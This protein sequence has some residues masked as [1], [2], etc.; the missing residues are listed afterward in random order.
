MK[1]VKI[2]LY[3]DQPTE[4]VAAQLKEWLE[5]K[6]DV[7]ISPYSSALT[8]FTD[9]KNNQKWDIAIVDLDGSSE[10]CSPDE[11]RE[12]FDDALQGYD[13]SSVLV[14]AIL[15]IG[16]LNDWISTKQFGVGILA[17]LSIFN[18]KYRCVLTNHGNEATIVTA[19]SSH[20]LANEVVM[21]KDLYPSM[22]SIIDYLIKAIM[23]DTVSPDYNSPYAVGLMVASGTAPF[24][25]RSCS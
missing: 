12:A 10:Q 24:S 8:F 22:Q 5:K 2:L 18:C 16:N 9:I 21:S 13:V 14:D 1:K 11:F 20:R 19:L 17:T 15:K 23:Q 6:E 25:R 4:T 3:D 7:E